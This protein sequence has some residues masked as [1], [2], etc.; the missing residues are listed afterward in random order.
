MLYWPSKKTGVGIKLLPK[1][2]GP[3][4]ILAQLNEVTYRIDNGRRLIAV[5]VERLRKYK[6]WV[7]N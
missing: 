5:H 3:Y 7:R 1:W 4:R 2:D 6:P